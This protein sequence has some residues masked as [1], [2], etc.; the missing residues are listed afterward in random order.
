MQFLLAG[1]RIS[2][3]DEPSPHRYDYILIPHYRN[4]ARSLLT[5]ENEILFL[6][7]DDDL[8][9]LHHSWRDSVASSGEPAAQ[10]VYDLYLI[11]NALVYVK[12]PC[13][14]S[15]VASKFFLHV[16]PERAG[17]LPAERRENGYENLD[18]NFFVQGMSLDGLCIARVPLPDRPSAAARTGQFD[19]RGELWNATVLL[20]LEALR[21]AYQ[22]AVSR[23]PDA[24]S[25]FTLYLNETD[26]TLTYVKEPCAAPDPDAP[27]FL[28]ARPERISD[29]PERRRAVGFDNLD[30]DF[31][32]RGAVFD[33]KCAALISLPEYPIADL[34]TGQWVQG[35]GEKWVATVRL[36]D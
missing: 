17:D 36:M 5:P 13:S 11:D 4:E 22:A 28:H 14:E 26:R 8:S 27:F 7:S 15:D 24:Q 2:Y 30:F 21:A 1:S 25:T 23:E 16:F 19:E 18:F 29:L 3:F 10:S 34:R 35:E 31:R 32:L 9:S 33:G 20:N 12:R 6:Y